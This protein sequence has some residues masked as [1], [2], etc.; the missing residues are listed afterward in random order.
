[1]L[2]SEIH[3]PDL[4]F[5]FQVDWTLLKNDYFPEDIQ[6]LIDQKGVRGMLRE[7]NEFRRLTPSDGAALQMSHGKDKHPT[8]INYMY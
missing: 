1:M 7:V 8:V 4:V 5:E 2:W 3:D 6:Q